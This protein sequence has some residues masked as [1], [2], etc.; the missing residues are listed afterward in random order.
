MKIDLEIMESRTKLESQLSPSSA[1]KKGSDAF[2]I[3]IP[4]G[5]S[6]CLM[7]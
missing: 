1:R 4:V 2:S 7:Q 6:V 5:S 3:V